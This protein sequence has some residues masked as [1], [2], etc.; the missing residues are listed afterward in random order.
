MIFLFF[1]YISTWLNKISFLDFLAVQLNDMYSLSLGDSSE[2][3]RAM[4]L[5]DILGRIDNVSRLLL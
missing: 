2:R 1:V 5:R 3:S 4:N